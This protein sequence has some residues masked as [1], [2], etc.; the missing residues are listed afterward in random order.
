M[1]AAMSFTANT[2]LTMEPPLSLTGVHP[3][4]GETMGHIK[5]VP[6]AQIR[7]SRAIQFGAGG[8]TNSEQQIRFLM[9]S[10]RKGCRAAWTGNN[11]LK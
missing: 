5:S 6:P 1:G 11:P 10:I 8:R 7:H 9:S 2:I 3:T 4:R